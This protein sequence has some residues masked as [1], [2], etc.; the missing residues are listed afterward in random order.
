MGQSSVRIK[1]SL[2]L[3]YEI[4]LDI[5]HTFLTFAYQ[6]MTKI[7][8]G[9]IHSSVNYLFDSVICFCTGRFYGSEEF[10][11]YPVFV[12]GEGEPVRYTG[13]F[14]SSDIK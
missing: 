2:P 13:R 7:K 11:L 14:Y 3:P 8:K 5:L 12:D 10:T 4:L 6:Y 1:R 9:F